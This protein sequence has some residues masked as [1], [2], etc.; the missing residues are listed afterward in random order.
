MDLPHG[1]W[2]NRNRSNVPIFLTGIYVYYLYQPCSASLVPTSQ[3]FIAC[4]MKSIL[5]AIKAWEIGL[6]TRLMQCNIARVVDTYV[7]Y[8]RQIRIYC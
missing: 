4:S 5:Q 7:S 6:G 3:A 2:W 8:I 1:C